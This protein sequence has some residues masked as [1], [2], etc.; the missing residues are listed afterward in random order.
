MTTN[1]GQGKGSGATVKAPDRRSWHN[2]QPWWTKNC[3]L[4]PTY[5]AAI[6]L[7][8]QARKN[9]RSGKKTAP[10]LRTWTDTLTSSCLAFSPDGKTLASVIRSE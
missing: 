7:C 10:N 2:Q 6:V 9:S 5:R 4:C 8:D 1:A 3:K